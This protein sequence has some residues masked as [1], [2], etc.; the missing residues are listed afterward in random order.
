M[1]DIEFRDA[2]RRY[3]ES[4]GPPFPL[5]ANA[6]MSQ[7]RRHARWRWGLSMG[8]ASAASI[9][10]ASVIVL[11]PGGAP[12]LERQGCEW[13][14]PPFVAPTVSPSASLWPSG[15][16]SPWPSDWPTSR[17]TDRPESSAQPTMYS[18]EPP[19]S[20]TATA[21]A[22]ANPAPQASSYPTEPV[23][24]TPIPTAEPPTGPLPGDVDQARIDAMSCYLKREM[25]QLFPQAAFAPPSADPMEVVRDVSLGDTGWQ[26]QYRAGAF[27]VEDQ[28]WRMI[29]VYVRPLP[30]GWRPHGDYQRM[31]TSAGHTAYIGLSDWDD[32][33]VTTGRS[34]VTISMDGTGL[35]IDQSIALATAPELDLYR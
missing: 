27:V 28:M 22:S 34:L 20:P 32:V 25:L 10:M 12:V 1:D 24:G 9:A 8:T 2:L 33:I 11:S 19:S 14:L 6:L 30:E 13:S 15:E 35:T 29:W 7:G 17:P 23:H 31:T 18:S 5:T 16:P 21:Q 4:G 3:S 26:A